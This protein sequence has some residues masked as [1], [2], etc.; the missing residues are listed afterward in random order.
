MAAYAGDSGFARYNPHRGQAA[1]EQTLFEAAQLAA[2]HS[3][4]RSGSGVPVDYA[5]VKF[6]KKPPAQSREW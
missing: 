5:A 6:V 4:G 1:G 2:F 3:K